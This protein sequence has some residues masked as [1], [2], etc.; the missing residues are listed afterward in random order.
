M[1]QALAG[2]LAFYYELVPSYAAA[3]GLLTLTVMLVLTPLTW[4][5]TRS[6]LEMQ[7][8]QPEI[9][10]LQQKH[11]GDRQK[12]NEEMVA[13]YKEH[14]VNPVA[15]CLPMLLQMPVLFVMYQVINGLTRTVNGVPQPKYLGSDTRLFQ[16]LVADGGQM[17]DLGMDLARRATD[18][19]DSFG[20]ALPFFVLVALVV[21]AQYVQTKQMQ[22]RNKAA[23]ANPQMQ[24]MTRVMPIVFGFISFSI[25]AGV[26]V[27]F[28]VSALFRIA[29]QEFMY[30]FDPVLKKHV[31]EQVK[32]VE[33]K[34]Y[35]KPKDGGKAA[36]NGKAP[37]AGNG[38]AA[39][40]S[41]NKGG[42]AK[43]KNRS[44]KGR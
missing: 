16:D 41:G 32:E 1:F 31:A 33:A 15:G 13:F 36:V 24:M 28:L 44:K 30:R 43:A 14:Q 39:K 23:Q 29:Q 37:K 17:R 19:H 27:Y 8:L 3:I 35:D 6:M 2:L 20:V 12:L 4:K 34:A 7:R 42:N 26:N 10:R 22:G 38:K 9:K 5:S 40:G 11:K 18:S 25:A 21:V